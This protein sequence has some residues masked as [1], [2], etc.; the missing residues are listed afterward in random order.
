MPTQSNDNNRPSTG[1]LKALLALAAVC[2]F[3]WLMT[4]DACMHPLG[5]TMALIAFLASG[6]GLLL[7]RVLAWTLDALDVPDESGVTE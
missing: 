4:H 6:V 2:A 1:P 7:P 5:N 3:V